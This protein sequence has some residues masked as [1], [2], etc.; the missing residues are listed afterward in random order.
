MKNVWLSLATFLVFIFFTACTPEIITPIQSDVAMSEID[1]I[2][3]FDTFTFETTTKIVVP[4]E[5]ALPGATYEIDTFI[6]FDVETFE[7][8]MEIVKTRIISKTPQKAEIIDQQN[9]TNLIAN[10]SYQIDTIITFNPDTYEETIQIIR[11]KIESGNKK[12]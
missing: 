5:E 9:K 7:E 1:T 8:T 12:N 4:N 10:E 3:M 11:T 6:T 2:I